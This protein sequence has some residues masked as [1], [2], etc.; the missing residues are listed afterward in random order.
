M[1][2]VIWTSPALSDLEAIADYIA[3][4]D[5]KAAGRLVKKVFRRIDQLAHFPETG[6]FIPELRPMKTHRQVIVR[7]CRIF[8]RY[9]PSSHVALIVGAMRSE[10]LFRAELLIRD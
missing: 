8:Y 3:L 7:P 9:D 4:D 10:R 5:P 6:S 1:A 2:Q